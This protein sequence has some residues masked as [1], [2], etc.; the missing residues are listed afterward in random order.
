M[1]TRQTS[2]QDEH[3]DD[4]NKN[5][6]EKQAGRPMSKAAWIPLSPGRYHL[7]VKGALTLMIIKA[8]GLEEITSDDQVKCR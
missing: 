6:R 5:G 2:V 7:I 1:F 8:A 3:G 4:E